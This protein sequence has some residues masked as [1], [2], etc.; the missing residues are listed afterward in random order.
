MTTEDETSDNAPVRAGEQDASLESQPSNNE[1]QESNG[2]DITMA[3]SDGDVVIPMVAIKE[4]IKHEVRLEDLFADMDSDEEFPSSKVEDI[5][6]SS[7]PP[8]T[9]SFV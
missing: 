8:P 4:E 7:S 9:S 6:L 2:T 3:E 1:S 5:K